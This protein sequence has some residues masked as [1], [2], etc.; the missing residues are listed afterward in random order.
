M[1]LMMDGQ[2]GKQTKRYVKSF[3]F[4]GV[5][6]NYSIIQSLISELALCDMMNG[7][8]QLLHC[9]R[10]PDVFCRFNGCVTNPLQQIE[11]NV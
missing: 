2:D 4:V 1:P 10:I 6:M 7:T 3:C 11:R 8:N 9:N 5:P